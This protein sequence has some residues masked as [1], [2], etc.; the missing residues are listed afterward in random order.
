MR[1]L[2]ETDMTTT[3]L[4]RAVLQEVALWM[5][6]DDAMQQLLDFLLS[7]KGEDSQASIAGLPY[8][9]KERKAS[10]LKAEADV[11]GGQVHPHDEVVARI[12]EK[13]ATWK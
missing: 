13:I 8:T 12:R 6:D 10:L 2:T 4:R 1:K 5:D 7:L 3:D 11:L 9:R